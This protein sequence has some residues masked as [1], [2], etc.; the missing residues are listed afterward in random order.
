MPRILALLML[1][2]CLSGCVITD[3]DWDDDYYYEDD[4]DY[5]GGSGA[6]ACG[7]VQTGTID[8]G[9]PLESPPGEAVGIFVDYEGEGRWHVFTTCDTASSGY[10]CEFDILA[11]PLGRSPVFDAQ[12]DDIERDDRLT[13][14]GSDSVHFLAYTALDT[15][16]FYLETDPGATL[17]LDVLL[18]GACGNGFLY[19]I[20]DGG[21][22]RGAPSNP[23]ELEPAAP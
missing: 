15:D 23:F 21:I 17:E 1:P 3:D 9:M 13:I 10:E 6:Y 14:E 12:P 20:G 8:V 22:H 18:D 4:G 5:W 7:H 16:G 11:T 2:L 19:W